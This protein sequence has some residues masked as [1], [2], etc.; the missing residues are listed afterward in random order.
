MQSELNK[1]MAA[2]GDE[3]AAWIDSVILPALSPLERF[4]LL[5]HLMPVRVQRWVGRRRQI[6]IVR[7][8]ISGG[9]RLT[10]TKGGRV[11]GFCDFKLTNDGWIRQEVSNA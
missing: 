6:A 9:H 8:L 1:Y 7:S 5:N 2:F 11:L 10:I 4:L 3:Q